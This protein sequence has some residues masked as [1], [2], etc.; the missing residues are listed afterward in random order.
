MN[1][2]EQDP[3]RVPSRDD[4]HDSRT[5]S[6]RINP[7]ASEQRGS[8]R[9]IGLLLTT[10][11]GIFAIVG[12]VDFFA[13]FSAVRS[14]VPDGPDK[15]WCLFVGL[16]MLG[17]G[18][19]IL[20]AGYL[21][22]MTRYVAGETAPVARDAMGA[23]LDESQDTIEGVSRSIARGIR[24]GSASASASAA[25]RDNAPIR[26]R[27]AK[28]EALRSDGIIDDEDFEEQKDRILNEI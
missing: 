10:V 1:R 20:R 26:E 16:P 17:V 23:L 5:M 28:L 18:I 3:S 14:G 12:A 4:R 27:I 15:F 7:H 21:G 6:R 13:S 11:G 9:A 22:T 25:N 2:H 19:S 24:E 8:L